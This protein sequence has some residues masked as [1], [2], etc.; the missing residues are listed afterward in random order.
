MRRIKAVLYAE[1]ALDYYHKMPP[2]AGYDS[3]DSL[4]DGRNCGSRNARKRRSLLY[5]NVFPESRVRSRPALQLLH[6]ISVG[7]EPLL[8]R[9]VLDSGVTLTNSRGANAKPV[10]EHAVSLMLALTRNIHLSVRAQRRKSWRRSE[11][12]NGIEVDG[13]TLGLIG[14]GAIAREI[15]RKAHHLG[16]NVLAVKRSVSTRDQA[17]QPGYVTL[18]PIDELHRMLQAADVVI[19]CLPL[20]A[21]TRNLIG[22]TELNQLKSTSYVI[23]ISRGSVIDEDALIEAL[24]EGRIAGAGLD[25]FSV[26]PLPEDSPLWESPQVI[27]TPYISA[28]SPHTMTR[29]MSIFADNLIRLGA[30]CRC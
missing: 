29:A 22:R 14:F 6:S 21:Q 15:A 17:E 19:L 26:H 13:L 12:R 30:E 20:T 3:S 1:Q 25:V 11:L 8:C 28:A 27:V 18:L 5:R 7:M 24:R 16:M 9:E 10:A 23:N 2:A 4:H